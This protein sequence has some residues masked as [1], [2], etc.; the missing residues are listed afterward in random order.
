VRYAHPSFK[1]YEPLADKRSVAVDV[2]VSRT[3]QEVPSV[4]H[5]FARLAAVPAWV[6]LGGIVLVSFG[7]RIFAA[8][9]RL[10]PY[11]LPDEY[12][13]PSLAR[14]LAEHG[15]PLIRGAGVHFP[16][17]L[18]PIVT[19]PVWLLT[20]DPT[21]AFR[22]TQ[23]IHAVLFSLAA[24]P[25][26]L[27]CRRLDLPRWL[28]IA[29][30]ALAVAVPDGVY[31]STMLAD[32]LAYPLVLAAVYAGVCVVA[33][34]SLRGQLAFAVFCALAVLA[35]IQYLA[36]PLAVIGAELVADRG[37]VLRSLRR[38]W[39]SLVLLAVPPLLLFGIFGSDRVLGVYS[40]GDHAVHPTLILHW[41]GLEA[42]LLA[43]SAGWTIVPGALAG[44]AV[45]LFRPRGRAELAFAVTTLMLAGALL[46]EAAQI[47]DTDSRRFQERYL[48]AL[49]PL[50]ATAFGL[51]V[52]RGLPGRI[53]VGLLSAAL[54]LLAARVPLSGYAAAHNKDDSPTLWAVLRLEG[55]LSV[56]NGSL[57]VALVAAALSVLAALVAFR[58]L[59]AAL[60]L[61]GAVAAGCAMSV[62][63]SSF[64]ALTSRS[65][66]MT[67]PSDVRWVDHSRLGAVDLLA[68]PGARKEQSWQQLFWNT[69]VKR[70]LLLG[71][72]PI[73]QFAAKHIRVADDGRLLV[74]GRADRRP[75]LVQTYA[76][77]VELTG[78][79]RVRHE[80]IFDLYRPTGTPRLR[81]LAAGRFADR[82]L[83]PRG[84]ITV[85]TKT[86][87]TL[88]LVL[89]MPAHSE[90][91]PIRF[92][93]KG[94]NR[95]V[96]VHPG[97]RIRL[98]FRVP[99]GGAWSLHFRG[100]K[101]GY[102]G[103]RA[104]SVLAERVR[105]R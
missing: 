97:K 55:L 3:D 51:Y 49:V 10:T 48:F 21:T 68:P 5:A 57:A 95:L 18:D 41:L 47:A 104:V 65:L 23:G 22:L 25:A 26:Y 16:A 29:V 53:P 102:L 92:T 87:G 99:A 30:A 74:D 28:G 39:L 7:G 89:S 45:V 56:G 24:I 42:M 37:H 80:L 77:T 33:N 83:A 12:I 73:D 75:L 63:A 46:L 35:R 9:A 14:S 59:P 82:W 72:P 98:S 88:Q 103:E 85:W 1:G 67:L 66:R 86:G 2:A 4:P 13:Y 31:S 15:R 58:K 50:L 8:A 52:K 34:P 96:R 19:A 93:T 69:S 61:I 44:L 81:L 62:G 40:N 43:Y 36:I 27:L 17:L 94:V 76:S 32:P 100:D 105:F 71:S 6:W 11:Y 79:K 54:L 78:M 20:D 84:A 91:T 101:Q 64:D 90:V 70:L 60:A 38:I